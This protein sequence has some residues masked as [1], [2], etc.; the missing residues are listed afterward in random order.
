MES[1]ASVEQAVFLFY[2]HVNSL[3]IR[4]CIAISKLNLSL[5]PKSTTML[6]TPL[7]PLKDRIFDPV[8]RSIPLFVTPLHLT[9]LAFISGLI[10]CIYAATDHPVASLT[11]WFL[12][13]ALDCLDGGV[14]RLRSQQSDF[15]GFLDLLGDFIVYSAIPISCGLSSAARARDATGTLWLAIAVVEAS[16]HVNNFV[17]FYVGAVVEKRRGLVALKKAMMKN[18]NAGG[19]GAMGD[20]EGEE[21]EERVKQL[22]SV[23]MRPALIEGVESA[24]LFTIMLAW[25]AYTEL[26]CWLMAGLVSVGICQRVVWIVPVL[27]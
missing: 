4:I 11:F 10:S 27:K 18:R 26:A 14:A 12:N 8:A 17:L 1:R 16:F 21:V 23:A 6:D 2:Y 3:S 5:D 24:V 20:R 13:R 15:G 25:P 19:E 7:R 22:T 9:L